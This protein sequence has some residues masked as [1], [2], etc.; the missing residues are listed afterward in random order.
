M[1][2]YI[3]KHRYSRGCSMVVIA[4]KTKEEAIKVSKEI[5]NFFSDEVKESTTLKYTG[6]KK[7][8]HVVDNIEFC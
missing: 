6:K 8:A 2:I 7:E 1:K 3:A 4:A 5:N